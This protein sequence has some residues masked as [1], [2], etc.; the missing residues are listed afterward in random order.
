M[1]K[2]SIYLDYAATTPLRPEV[3][4]AM[5]PFWSK[6]FGNPSSLYSIGKEANLALVAAR[7]KVSELLK[8]KSDEIVF[9]AGGSESL[10]LAILGSAKA[11]RKINKTGGHIISSSIEHKTVLSCLGQLE[12]EGFTV[13]RVDVDKEGFFNSDSINKAV[14]KDTFL[15]TLIYANNEIGTIEPISQIGKMLN[16]LNKRREKD[17]LPKIVFHT[18][19]C[20]ASGFL[21]ITPNNLGVDLL[22]INGSKIYG[23]KQTGCLYVKKG[24]SLEPII[25][26]G[27]QERGLRS[28]TENVPGVLGFATALTLS[29]KEK[30]KEAKRLSGLR[31]WFIKEVLKKVQDTKLNG[32]TNSDRLPNNINVSFSGCEGEALMFYLDAK[33]FAVSTGSACT[34]SS[35]EPSH[36]LEA[37]G[38]DKTH[39]DGSLRITLGKYTSKKDLESLM[40]IL[41]NIVAQQRKVKNLHNV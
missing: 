1:N 37:I 35:S 22:T 13:T 9:T 11:Y 12:N 16:G 3:V 27:G 5:A 40:K 4:K 17:Y 8:V 14:E 18:D 41:P 30:N 10:N 24:T 20:Q 38:L 21:D 29:N 23:P 39:L 34:S 15:V 2:K 19:A 31:D 26:G 7:K 6:S 33:G 28:G 36:V 25:Y 32:P